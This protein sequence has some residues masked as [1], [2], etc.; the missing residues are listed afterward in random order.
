MHRNSSQKTKKKT[1]HQK[2]NEPLQKK[3]TQ[4]FGFRYEIEIKAKLPN[5]NFLPKSTKTNM[6]IP[7][8]WGKPQLLHQIHQNLLKTKNGLSSKNSLVLFH[9]IILDVLTY[10]PV[11]GIRVLHFGHSFFSVIL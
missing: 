6:Q 3:F 7:R 10:F 1:K 4:N 8:K 2:I 9:S 11:M 5:I